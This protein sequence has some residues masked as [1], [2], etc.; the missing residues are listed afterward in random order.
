[1]VEECISFGV[2]TLLEIVSVDTV[3]EHDTKINTN[4]AIHANL[5]DISKS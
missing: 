1:M 3:G 5:R 2:S 4:T